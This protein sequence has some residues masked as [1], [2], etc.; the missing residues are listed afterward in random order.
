MGRSAAYNSSSSKH[1]CGPPLFRGVFFLPRIPFPSKRPQKG[2]EFRAREEEEEDQQR[3]T[4][5]VVCF[6][7][8]DF[9]DFLP[10]TTWWVS[11]TTMATLTKRK[12]KT[13]SKSLCRFKKWCA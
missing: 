6:R 5:G 4:R 8:D 12:R 2:S 10:T 1:R 7:D 13:S 9:D 3:R 11:I